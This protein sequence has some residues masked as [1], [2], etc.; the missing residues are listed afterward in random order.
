MLS[1]ICEQWISY[2]LDLYISISLPIS[3]WYDNQT[4]I[5]I[6]SNLIFHERAKHLDIDLVREK[7]KQEFI[8]PCHISIEL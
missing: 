3:F 1:P 5:H 2:I 7:F 8:H 4:A 6:V